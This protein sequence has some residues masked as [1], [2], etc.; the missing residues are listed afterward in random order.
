[1]KEAVCLLIVDHATITGDDGPTYLAATRRNNPSQGGFPGGKVDPGETPVEAII[2]ET[3][4]EV[5]LE[6]DPSLL[7]L[8]YSGVCQGKGPEDTYLV[9]TFVTT[10]RW[11]WKDI[12]V[13]EGLTAKGMAEY[14]LCSKTFSPFADYNREVFI[15]VKERPELLS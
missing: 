3:H 11:S 5:G 10:Q 6:L 15:A 8:V 13:E 1:M 4:E 7:K 2:R 12:V 9:H 14:D